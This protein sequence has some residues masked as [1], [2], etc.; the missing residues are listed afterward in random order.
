MTI[1][2][3]DEILIWSTSPERAL[4]FFGFSPDRYTARCIREKPETPREVE[5]YSPEAHL[6]GIRR[7]VD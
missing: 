4:E 5:R 6:Y 2:Y 3:V 7:K 1:E